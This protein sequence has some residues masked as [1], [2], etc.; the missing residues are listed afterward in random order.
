MNTIE[1]IRLM[2]INN[3]LRD[4]YRRFNKCLKDEATVSTMVVSNALSEL[5][6]WIC[7][8][9]EWHMQNNKD[10]QY[11][12]SR[13]T[14]PG[15]R[16]VKGLR[17]A[18]NSIKHVMSFM[19]LIGTTGSKIFLREEYHI[20]DFTTDVIWLD[21]DPLIE[22]DDEFKHQRENY[23]KYVEREKVVDT[24]NTAC[25]FLNDEYDKVN[26]SY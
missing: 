3:G 7:I 15:G 24:I 19:S 5:L 14:T 4:S 18:F 16:Y 10:G 22:Y 11:R 8:S 9:D 6:M 21:A 25:R 12:K 2:H 17:Y 13:H 1:D 26:R 23:I 20:A